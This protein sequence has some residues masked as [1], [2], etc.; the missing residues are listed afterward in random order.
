LTGFI[1]YYEP[2]VSDDSKKKEKQKDPLEQSI[3]LVQSVWNIFEAQWKCRNDILHSNDSALIERSQ[4][5]LTTRLLEFKQ[6][7]KSLLRSCDRFIIDNHS[8][9]DVIKWPLQQ[10]KAVIDLLERLHKVYSG[11]LKAD[12]APL[13]VTFR[14]I[15]LNYHQR[16]RCRWRHLLTRIRII[17]QIRKLLNLARPIQRSLQMKNL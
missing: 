10:K 6:D 12:T 5:T 11:E 17:V 2:R 8:I 13:T 16:T 3:V 9:Q 7:S 15:L 4:D 14:T 1:T